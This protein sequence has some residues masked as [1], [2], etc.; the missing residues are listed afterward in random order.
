MSTRTS[1]FKKETATDSKQDAEISTL[2]NT[3]NNLVVPPAV[4]W[5]TQ[6]ATSDVDIN[7]N[8]LLNV[9]QIIAPSGGLLLYSEGGNIECRSSFVAP[10]IVSTTDITA[11]QNLH[12][13]TIT[14]NSGTLIT[15]EGNMTAGDLTCGTLHYTTLSPAI[16]TPNKSLLTYYVDGSC[17]SDSNDGSREYPFRLIQS[18]INKCESVWDGTAREIKVGFGTYAEN[19]VLSK[20]RIQLTGSVCSRYANVACGINGTITLNISNAVDMFNSQVMITGF[21]IVGSVI[22]ASSSV[23]TLNIKDCFLYGQE[24][25]IQQKTRGAE[26][27]ANGNS[28]TPP[29]YVSVDC[30]TYLENLT[31]NASNASGTTPLISIEAGSLEMTSCNITAKSAN[32]NC[33]QITKN[34]STTTFTS[35]NFTNDNTGSTLKPLILVI[36]I[37]GSPTFNSFVNCGFIFGSTAAKTVDNSTGN[38]SAIVCRNRDDY[39]NVLRCA[40]ALQGVTANTT[41][42]IIMPLYLETASL[43]LAQSSNVSSIGTAYKV[44]TSGVTSLA[45]S[46]VS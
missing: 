28:F 2:T 26:I 32:T 4:Q 22:D 9:S 25:I 19:L 30:R 1:N 44:C 15:V 36:G 3:L 5:S 10:Y 11:L 42:F 7:Y 33:L 24:N 13:N 46:T 40:F 45:F 37:L 21:Q 35:S 29:Q 23:H 27:L 18:A 12:T 17:G 8:S 43:K 14:P 16:P 20:A 38:N 31:I 34:A 39:F 6:Q 41:N